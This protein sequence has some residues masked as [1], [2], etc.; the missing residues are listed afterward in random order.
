MKKNLLTFLLMLVG[1]TAF[2]QWDNPYNWRLDYADEFEGIEYCYNGSTGFYVQFKANGKAI[3]DE[4]IRAAAFIG[5]SCRAFFDGYEGNITC[6]PNGNDNGVIYGF[7]VWGNTSANATTNEGSELNKDVVFGIYSNNLLFKVDGS[8]LGQTL[9]FD[10]EAHGTPSDPIVINLDVPTGVTAPAIDEA[11]RF[12][13]SKDMTG[14]WS[15]TYTLEDGSEY[16]PMEQAELITE[17]IPTW[18]RG[19][20]GDVISFEDQK[21]TVTGET[22]GEVYLKI[23]GTEY[24][25][26]TGAPHWFEIFTPVSVKFTQMEI[27]VTSITCSEESIQVDKNPNLILGRTLRK[28]ITINPEDATNQD[29]T[30]SLAED[31]PE[32]Y[33]TGEGYNMIPS[34]GTGE[35]YY[36]IIISSV[37]NPEVKASIWVKIYAPVEDIQ[38]PEDNRVTINKGDNI[39]EALRDYITVLPEDAT[40]KS[41]TLT[42]QEEDAFVDDIA[43]RGSGIDG[44]YYGIII[45]SNDNPNLDPRVIDVFVN[46]APTTITCDS[47]TIQMDKGQHVEKMLTGH[48][49]VGPEDATNQEWTYEFYSEDSPVDKDGFIARAGL[50]KVKVFCPDFPEVTTDIYINVAVRPERI[51]LSN[52]TYSYRVPVGTDIFE[53]LRGYVTFDPEDA[54]ETDY[55][56]IVSDEASDAIVDGIARR[57]GNYSSAIQIATTGLEDNI[58]TFVNIEIYVAVEDIIVPDIVRMEVGQSLYYYLDWTSVNIVPEDADQGFTIEYSQDAFDGNGNATA[59]GNYT[60]TVRSVADPNVSKQVSVEVVEAL[61]LTYPAFIEASKHEETTFELTCINEGLGIDVDKLEVYFSNFYNDWGYTPEIYMS[62]DTGLKWT[63]A[64]SALAGE[65]MISV[66]Y[67]GEEIQSDEADIYGCTV[68]VNAEVSF[69]PNGWDWIYVPGPVENL[70]ALNVD[71][72]NKVI[73]IR[74]QTGMLYNDPEYG[75]FGDIYGLG[76]WDGMYKIK[77]SFADE[78]MCYIAASTYWEDSYKTLRRGYNWIGYTQ[79][80]DMNLNE[81]NEL[82]HSEDNPNN[83]SEG[84][85]ILSKDGFIIYDSEQQ[86]WISADN[87]MF[88]VGKGY[89]YYAAEQPQMECMRF[90]S[91]PRFLLPRAAHVKARKPENKSVWQYDASQFADNMGIVAELKN[92]DIPANYTIGAFVDGECRGKGKIVKGNI[93]LINVAGKAGETVTFRLHNEMTGEYSD[94]KESAAYS[95]M[96]G[97]LAAPLA[98]T[99]DGNGTTDINGVADIDEDDIVAIYTL[100]GKKVTEMT[101]GIYII[102][103]RENGKIVTKKVKK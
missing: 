92:V 67:D 17:L 32:G 69:N 61:K 44:I 38:T 24:V 6:T 55:E 3:T 45:T 76:S 27:P 49:T 39:Y 50:H 37:S 59:T 29:F 11:V 9:K 2:A 100:N 13:Y 63:I 34:K 101:E 51:Y 26:P 42:P 75:F 8:T 66:Y 21:L 43:V 20:M 22:E 23:M 95:M 15:L 74:S 71:E 87:F 84:D 72:N 98:L 88:E 12:P 103:I 19:Q 47:E 58:S 41:Y 91:E 1:M 25:E 82:I 96:A 53:M 90:W 46:A 65:Y 4:S 102:Q 73:E 57:K 62:D 16:S 70:D 7:R 14:T 36:K 30:L 83:F 78:S 60:V 33:F 79:E 28:Y 10:G 18:D 56:F 64:A 89:I 40:D 54:T 86:E 68:V 85:F 81:F 52:D 35:N 93:A 97:S 80:W 99:A 31:V 48:I 5:E 94:I 77:S